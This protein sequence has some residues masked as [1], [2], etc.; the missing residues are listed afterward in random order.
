MRY[1]FLIDTYRTEIEKTLGV[2]AMFEDEDMDRRP[3]PTDPRGRTPRE[4]MIHHCMGEFG[5]L[6]KI[7]GLAV[8][9]NPLPKEETRVGFIQTYAANARRQLEEL[10]ACDEAWWEEEVT[11]FDA[12]RSRA[13][14]FLRRLTH[15]SHHRGQLTAMLRM[16]GRPLHSTYGPTADTGGLPQ[17]AAKVIYAYPDADTLVREESGGRHKLP[18]PDR[19]DKPVTERPGLHS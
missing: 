6:T 1:Q 3:H 8:E 2:W 5:W 19:C 15:S 4:Q 13:W 10:S 7:L 11:F 18:L 17:N 16:L 12:R 9:G 14:I